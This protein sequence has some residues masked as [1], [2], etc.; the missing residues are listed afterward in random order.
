MRGNVHMRAGEVSK[1]LAAYQEA[2]KLA[3][4][5]G[6]ARQLLANALQESGQ[7]AQA[8]AE[9]RQAIELSHP[10]ST[11]GVD[12]R[13]ELAIQ[14]FHAGKPDEAQAMLR[15]VLSHRRDDVFAL[16]RLAEVH[17]A[18]GEAEPAQALLASVLTRD[19]R[20]VPA[21]LTRLRLATA[22]KDWDGATA[23]V[24]ELRRLRPG[25]AFVDYEL[26]IIQA[27]RG[28]VAASVASLKTALA[29]AEPGA[30]AKAKADP[31]LIAL[32]GDPGFLALTAP[33]K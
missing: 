28:D 15:E 17:A 7:G 14:L 22:A 26:A 9:Y 31:R 19:P 27:G 30:R 20:N 16:N 4:A 24:A 6:Q 2:V 3:P 11:V 25:E 12:S 8:Q 23:I 13:R 5:N 29:G 33:G 32:T 21:R 1:A 10:A 18:K